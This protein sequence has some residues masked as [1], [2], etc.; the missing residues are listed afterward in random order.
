MIVVALLLF[1]IKIIILI[2]GMFRIITIIVYV[3]FHITNLLILSVKSS[4][5][6]NILYVNIIYYIF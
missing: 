6:L 4:S 1:L 3:I 2:K 5:K